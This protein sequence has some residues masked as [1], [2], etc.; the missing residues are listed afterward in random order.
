MHGGYSSQ[1]LATANT[2]AAT[3]DLPDAIVTTS[4]LKITPLD[5]V[6]PEAAQ[7]L[8]GQCA[9]LEPAFSRVQ[10]FDE[11][12]KEIDK[13]MFITVVESIR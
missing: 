1:S 7:T 8:I 13:K 11:G 10:V 2:L 5:A 4:G 12:G 9:G 3:N 6:V